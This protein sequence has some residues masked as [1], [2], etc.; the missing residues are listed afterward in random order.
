M[1]GAAE[2]GLVVPV[3]AATP[4]VAPWRERL[5]RTA[6][7]GVPAHI[8]VL[9]PFLPPSQL[10]PDVTRQLAELF[11]A[12]PPFDFAL[13]RV[14]WFDDDVV[15]LAPEPAEPFVALTRLVAHAFPEYPPYEGAYDQVTPHL[16]VGAGPLAELRRAADAVQ[17]SLPIAARAGDVWLMVGTAAPAGRWRVRARFPLGGGRLA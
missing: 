8:T 16:T 4:A 11:A 15:Y 5:D 6:V 10:G 14:G 17:G 7:H 12:T 9:Y 1:N 3:P 13:R 2:T